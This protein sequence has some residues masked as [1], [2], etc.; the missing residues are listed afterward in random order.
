M[1]QAGLDIADRGAEDAE[2]EDAFDDAGIEEMEGDDEGDDSEDGDHR[3]SDLMLDRMYAEY[4]ERLGGTSQ[5]LKREA[6][7][8]HVK[9][10]AQMSDAL[11]TQSAMH[12]NDMQRYLDQL[13]SGGTKKLRPDEADEDEDDEDSSSSEDEADDQRGSEHEGADGAGA[14]GTGEIAAARWVDSHPLLA[15]IDEEEEERMLDAR[16]GAP[17]HHDGDAA[18]DASSS[19]DDDDS[20]NHMSRAAQEVLAAMPKTDKQKRHEARVKLM[21]R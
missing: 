18:M 4:Q 11:M 1:T 14:S 3:T 17:G 12:D 20:G 13:G 7:R 21:A 5:A 19:S 8:S 10:A 16:L 9:K 6:K 2:W 15:K